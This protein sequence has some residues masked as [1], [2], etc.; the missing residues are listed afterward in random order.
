MTI[1]AVP[2][3]PTSP[4]FQSRVSFRKTWEALASA[5]RSNNLDAA[6]QAYSALTQPNGAQSGPMNALL[7]QIGNDL[8]SGNLSSALQSLEQSHERLNAPHPSRHHHRKEEGERQRSPSNLSTGT[9]DITI[10][11]SVTVTISLDIT[12]GESIS[13]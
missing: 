1:S 3:A 12:V 10:T 5:L 9:S 11:E 7:T 6:K 13:S 4:L 8:Q 2:N